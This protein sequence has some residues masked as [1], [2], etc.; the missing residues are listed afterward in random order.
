MV[1]DIMR[2]RLE[3]TYKGKNIADVL[4]MTALEAAAILCRAHAQLQNV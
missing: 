1:N 4:E 2:K 3:I